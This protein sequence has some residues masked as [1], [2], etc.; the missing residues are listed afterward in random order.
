MPR[1]S[2]TEV[3]WNGRRWTL[4]ELSAKCGMQA[5][6]LRYRILSGWPIDDAVSKPSQRV[7]RQKPRS[8]RKEEREALQSADAALDAAVALE[9][10]PP[11]ER[12]PQP[13]TDA[14]PRQRSGIPE[15]LKALLGE[16]E[17]VML[18]TTAV[19]LR[20]KKVLEELRRWRSR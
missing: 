20:R 1:G 19:E 7:I 11:W 4:A 10:A 8:E 9:S 13:T 2:I 5:D 14:V 17:A 3:E 6:T 18:A 12:H 16:I 15:E